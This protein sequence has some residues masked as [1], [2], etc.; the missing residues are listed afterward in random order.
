MFSSTL[1]TLSAVPVLYIVLD[2]LPEW[3]KKRGRRRSRALP[4]GAKETLS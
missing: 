4:A 3:V 2:D 1:L